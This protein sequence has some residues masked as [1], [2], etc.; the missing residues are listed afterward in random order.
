MGDDSERLRAELE[1]ELEQLSTRA[2]PDDADEPELEPYAARLRALYD[3]VL[4]Q[5]GGAS[6]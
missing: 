4:V 6:R 3:A 1:V 5:E 2:D